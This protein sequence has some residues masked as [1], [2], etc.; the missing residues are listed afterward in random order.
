[1][2][3]VL[4]KTSNYLS[5][6]KRFVFL[7][8]L[9][10]L[11]GFSYHVAEAAPVTYN[12]NTTI[13]LSGGNITVASGS[14]ADSVVV[15]TTGVT[16]VLSAST[17]GN[18]VASS[19]GNQ[20]VSTPD[21]GASKNCSSPDQ[22]SQITLS[23]AGSYVVTLTSSKC[24]LESSGSS[25]GSSGSSSG[26]GSTSATS[27]VSPPPIVAT[28]TVATTTPV[29]VVTSTQLVSIPTA[30]SAQQQLLNALISQ[31][32]ALLQQ[33]VGLGIT[34]PAGTEAY[35]SSVGKLSETGKNLSVGSIGE[36]VKLLQ[37]FLNSKGFMVA[38][39]GPGSLGNET[40]KFGALTKK[41]L[42]KYQASVG[43][44]PASGLFGPITRAYLKS[45]GF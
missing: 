5:G 1:M 7:C 14:V 32:K 23:S 28:T 45:I 12:V 29:V 17:G 38:E 11:V 4:R 15:D 42:A 39:S 10:L 18:F 2:K 33:A 9:F 13:T 41:A 34:L 24:S 40:T 26:G 25:G 3:N 20:L 37:Q 31:L 43:I 19:T 27:V 36:E 8:L 22:V 6:N 21:T 44:S 30:I 16:V 35:L